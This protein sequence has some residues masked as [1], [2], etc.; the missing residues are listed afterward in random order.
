MTSTET[1]KLR[2]KMLAHSG[3][4]FLSVATTANINNPP[5]M[6]GSVRLSEGALTG[7]IILRE[8]NLLAEIVATF[9]P[10]VSL[11]FIDC[12]VKAGVDLAASAG[13]LISADKIH[14]FKPNDF[15]V[16]ALDEWIAQRVRCTRGRTAAV[17]GAGNIGAKI[18]LR[19]SERGFQVRLAGRNIDKTA[20]IAKALNTISRGGGTIAAMENT[21]TA[22]AGADLILGCTPGVA[23]ID[24]K[25]IAAA[26]PDALLIDVGNGT[27]S[28][29][30]I[31]EAHRRSLALEVLA[32]NAGWDGFVRRYFSTRELQRGLGRRMLVN[33]VWIVSRGVMGSLGDV[34][35][36]NVE[37][38]SR[39]IGV[40]NGTGDLLYGED[41]VQRMKFVEDNLG[42]V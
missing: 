19:L 26:A 35:V 34:L 42:I 7:N 3:P 9:E 17:V 25:E 6:I 20:M 29:A 14:Y 18:A 5:L 24:T 8:S 15:T 21:L 36:D 30:A 12:E 4:R 31:A 41:A 11:F 1:L 23:A 40:C 10:V 2:D 37:A 28:A 16:E 27:F 32:P 22:C 33:D 39:V 38:P 13:D